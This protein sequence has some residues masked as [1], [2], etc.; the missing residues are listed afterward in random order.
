MDQGYLKILF[1]T[2][3]KE[4]RTI[5]FI[6]LSVHSYLIKIDRKGTD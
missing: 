4:C 5:I 1:F 2:E 6:E 3:R